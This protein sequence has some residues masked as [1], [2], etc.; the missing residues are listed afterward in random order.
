MQRLTSFLLR[1]FPEVIFLFFLCLITW[2]RNHVLGSFY[3][4]PLWDEGWYLGII[5]NGYFVNPDISQQ[6]SIAF[7][8]LYPLVCKLLTLVIPGIPTHLAMLLVSW[9]FAYLT[10]KFL[11]K[12]VSFYYPEHI[13]VCAVI[14]FL[15]MP[16]TFYIFLAYTESL[17]FAE[18]FSFIYYLHIKKRET[19]PL[20]I[21]GLASATRLYGI[22]LVLIFAWEFLRI[23][24]ASWLHVIKL[25]PIGVFGLFLFC[26]YQY[27]HYGNGL[28]FFQSQVAWNNEA[29][30]DAL[31]LIRLKN[32]L[33]RGFAFDIPNVFCLTSLLF[34]LGGIAIFQTRIPLFLRM[35]NLLLLIFFFILYNPE[36]MA[37]MGRYLGVLFIQPLFLATSFWNY[38]QLYKPSKML[39]FL[40]LCTLL[41]SINITLFDSF[42]R[43]VFV[44]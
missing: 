21:A 22:L 18:V 6:S 20:V 23:R 10:I 27:Y 34:M 42:C 24:K 14:A 4:V 2:L 19:V 44:G 32:I 39:L 36:R 15:C 25:L 13:S 38:D 26:M 17:W 29:D 28:L 16:F 35:S 3:G 43:G 12:I 40:F 5:E 11:F 33:S 41:L 8:P 9:F 37:S 1:Y 30:I 31:S 7:F